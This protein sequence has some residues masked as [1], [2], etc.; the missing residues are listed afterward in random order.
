MPDDDMLIV[1]A[2]KLSM[3]IYQG[4]IGA[5][6]DFCLPRMCFQKLSE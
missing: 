6:F 2:D 4:E 5:A 3:A 1:T